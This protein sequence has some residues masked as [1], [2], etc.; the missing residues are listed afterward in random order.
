MIRVEFVHQGGSEIRS[1]ANLGVHG[2][3]RLQLQGYGDSIKAQRLFLSLFY[4]ITV[5][6]YI[7]GVYILNK[8]EHF[9]SLAMCSMC[10]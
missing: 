9:S 2:Q 6:V 10:S 5:S 3:G 4:N 1:N 8:W 7:A